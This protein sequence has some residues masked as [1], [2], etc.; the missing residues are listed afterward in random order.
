MIYPKRNIFGDRARI[1]FY[2]TWGVT[3]TMAS[4]SSEINA[5]THRANDMS[6][7]VGLAGRTP[8]MNA[9]TSQF[10]RY[11]IK[12]YKLTAKCWAGGSSGPTTVANATSNPPICVYFM[13]GQ[14]SGVFPAASV[15]V[16]PE[17]RW[18]KYRVIGSQNAGAKPTK[19]SA[20]YSINK[21]FGPDNIV[22][23]DADFTGTIDLQGATPVWNPP[24]AG[25]A[26]RCGFFTMGGTN[27]TAAANITVLHTLTLYTEYFQR[28]QTTV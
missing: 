8:G 23:N 1:K 7:W 22:K 3:Y 18:A 13:A 21:T 17:Q 15:S 20:Y 16:I 14:D 26:I 5:F 11:R 12:G 2:I 9:L 4:G 25:P 10:E 28:F 24:N 6:A 27:V 19:L